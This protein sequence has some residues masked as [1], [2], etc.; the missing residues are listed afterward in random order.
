MS[1]AVYAKTWDDAHCRGCLHT[2][3]ANPDG[4]CSA[5]GYNGVDCQAQPCVC[6]DH[7]V[8]V[9]EKPKDHQGD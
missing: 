4:S 8:R 9:H 2:N 7:Q 1:Y 3:P 5:Y 6:R